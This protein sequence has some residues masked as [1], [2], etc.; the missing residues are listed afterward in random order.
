MIYKILRSLFA[1]FAGLA[2]AVCF[3]IGVELAS[4][5]LH[6]FPPGFDPRDPE[7]CR[8]HVARYPAGVLALVVPAWG[9]CTL[10][11]SWLATRIGTARHAA[12]GIVVGSILILLAVFNM[13]ML[14]Y[15]IWFW[16]G[17]LLVLPAC[18]FLGVRLGSRGL[19]SGPRDVG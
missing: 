16:V 18:L 15:P 8:A 10:V 9:L 5:V 17:N 11:S 7:A 1:V 14:P 13:A 12:H 3:M 6:P 2:V 19:S 4:A